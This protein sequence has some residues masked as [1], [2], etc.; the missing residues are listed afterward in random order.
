M[1]RS[2][3]C[4]CVLH[5]EDDEHEFS[6]KRFAKQIGLKTSTNVIIQINKRRMTRLTQANSSQF[7]NRTRV[8]LENDHRLSSLQRARG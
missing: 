4:G 1:K 5:R 8:A 7:P 2:L 6:Q 3:G